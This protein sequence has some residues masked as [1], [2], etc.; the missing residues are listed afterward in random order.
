[1]GKYEKNG[2]KFFLV[3]YNEKQKNGYCSFRS[4]KYLAECYQ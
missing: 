1:M 2:C 3:C 4:Q